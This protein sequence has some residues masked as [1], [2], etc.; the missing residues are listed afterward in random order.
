MGKLMGKVIKYRGVHLKN[1]RS[2]KN[3]SLKLQFYFKIGQ[4][5][6]WDYPS[7]TQNSE[8]AK[9]VKILPPCLC[10]WISQLPYLEA[11]RVVL[12]WSFL[13]CLRCL[14]VNTPVYKIVPHVIKP[15][16]NLN[17]LLLWRTKFDGKLSYLVILTFII[18]F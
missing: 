16:D 10:L 13:S 14:Q 6:K 18:C 12:P 5:F 7:Q 11:T 15:L 4:S 2:G 8:S 17:L 3:H 1:K 9:N